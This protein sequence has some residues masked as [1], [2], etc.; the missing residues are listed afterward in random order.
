MQTA[1]MH[2]SFSCQIPAFSWFWW[3]CIISIW[4]TRCCCSQRL[5]VLTEGKHSR[6]NNS[7]GLLNDLPWNLSFY[8]PFPQNGVS[9]LKC[10]LMT[11]R[12]GEQAA[13]DCWELC[14]RLKLNEIFTSFLNRKELAGGKQVKILKRE[15][16]CKWLFPRR[17]PQDFSSW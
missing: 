4:W 2:F 14:L 8:F 11:D 17:P 5:W 1:L 10:L 9:S 6:D 3:G 12:W 7:C 16:C 15:C 13:S